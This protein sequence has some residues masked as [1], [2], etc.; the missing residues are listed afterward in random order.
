MRARRLLIVGARQGNALLLSAEQVVLHARAR[1]VVGA[2]VLLLVAKCWLSQTGMVCPP[3]GGVEGGDLLVPFPVV[4]SGV[5]PA[6]RYKPADFLGGAAS[7]DQHGLVTKYCAAMAGACGEQSY[8]L[9]SLTSGA[10]YSNAARHGEMVARAARAVAAYDIDG[11]GALTE[12]ELAMAVRPIP[13]PGHPTPACARAS[14][15]LPATIIS[16]KVPWRCR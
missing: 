2:V 7:I 10:T 16:D 11:D 3:E 15:V 13:W 6:R 8:S 4:D 14:L 5:T 9:T 1:R 12:A